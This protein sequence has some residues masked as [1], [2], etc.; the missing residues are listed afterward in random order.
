MQ[1]YLWGGR[2]GPVLELLE[3]LSAR[4]NDD[5][6]RGV[7][8]IWHDESHLNKFFIE[9]KASV[10]TLDPGFAFPTIWPAAPFEKKILHLEKNDEEFGNHGAGG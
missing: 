6:A 10:N 3:T 1:G 2:S 8:A 4:I 9:H 5:L 7:I